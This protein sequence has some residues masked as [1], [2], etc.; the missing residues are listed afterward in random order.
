MDD[1]ELIPV[2]VKEENKWCKGNMLYYSL[3]FLVLL[4]VL[5]VIVALVS[6]KT[7]ETSSECDH[8]ENC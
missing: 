6:G 7:D 8:F 1:S 2:S 3:F 5:V 4:I